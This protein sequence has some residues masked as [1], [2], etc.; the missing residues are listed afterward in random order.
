[1]QCFNGDNIMTKVHRNTKNHQSDMS[2]SQF[3]IQQ[4]PEN[5]NNYISSHQTFS[6]DNSH[7]STTDTIISGSY[8]INPSTTYSQQMYQQVSFH[9]YVSNFKN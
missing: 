9:L 3:Q 6:M 1:M 7:A 4:F 2:S 8:Y 5:S